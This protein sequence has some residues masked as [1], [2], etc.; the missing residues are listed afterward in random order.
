MRTVG[1]GIETAEQLAGLTGLGCDDGQG[2]LLA[3]PAAPEQ[4]R[5]ALGLA[6]E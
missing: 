6:P 3:R 2:C 4:L 1:E 5:A